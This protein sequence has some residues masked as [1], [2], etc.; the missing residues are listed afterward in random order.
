MI[1]KMLFVVAAMTAV[2]FFTRAAP[3]LFFARKKPP[4]VF[5]YLQRYIPPAIM[6]ILVLGSFKDIDFAAS[7]H[8]LPAIAGALVTAG[9]HFWRRNVLV[10]ITGGTALYMLLIRIL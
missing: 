9:L 2:T 5:D 7:P 8:G 1:A 3:F 10:S 4:A 6:V